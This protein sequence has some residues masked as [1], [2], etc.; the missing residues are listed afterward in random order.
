MEKAQD[1]LEVLE[2]IREY[3]KNGWFDRDVEND[4]PTTPLKPGQVDYTLKKLSSKISSEIANRVAKNYFDKLIK[5][6]QLIIKEVRGLENY[7]SVADKGAMITCN[8]FNAFD[9]Y[10]VF[11]AIEKS[12]GRKRLYKVIREGNYTS[13]PGLYG[14]FF[15][16]CNTLPLG[17]NLAVLRELMVAVDVLLKRGEK[18][19]IYP[20]QGMWWN[21]RKPR[22]LKEGAFRFAARSSA[23]VVPFFITMED[24]ETYGADGFPLQAY[25]V[26]ILEPIYPDASKN[27]KQNAL[28]MKQKNYLAWKKVYEETYGIPLTYTTVTENKCFTQQPSQQQM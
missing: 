26:H 12:L 20:E 5:E 2:K 15:R 27:V 23:P 8:H 13:F 22:P 16:H 10:A 18:I 1:R 25:T 7:L 11:K 17:S 6:G 28:E 3:E 9:N 4:P 21:Y 24:T 19:L 14:Y